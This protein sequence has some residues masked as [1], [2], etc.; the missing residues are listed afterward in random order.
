MKKIALL[1][2]LLFL[3][4]C[5]L[6][7]NNS[8]NLSNTD[9]NQN[10]NSSNQDGGDPDIDP[11]G[12]DVIDAELKDGPI[13]HAWGW[14]T[15]MVK[16]ALDDIKNAGYKSVQLSPLQ[17]SKSTYGS[18][19]WWNLYQ[20]QG[21]VI[22]TGSDNPLGNKDSLKEL[23]RAANQKGVAIIMDV[24]TNH[25]GGP[26]HYT[27]DSRVSNYESKIVSDNL[28]H[29]NG[30]V[31]DWNNRYQVVTRAMG[32]YPDVLTSNSYVQDRIIAMLNDY[33]D[34]G[35]KGFRFDAAKSIETPEDDASCNSNYWPRVIGAINEHGQQVNGEKP[36][37]YGEL[38]DNPCI[39][40]EAYT[41]Y[42]SITDNRQANKVR[43]GVLYNRVNDAAYSG[44][45]NE[46]ASTN[47]L[48]AESH[49]TYANDNGATYDCSEEKMNL[50]YAIQVSRKDATALFFARPANKYGKNNDHQVTDGYKIDFKSPIIAAANKLHNDF[51]GGSE[52]LS[53]SDSAVINVRKRNKSEGALIADINCSSSQKTVNVNP[54]SNGVYVDLVNNNEYTVKDGSVTVTLT[55]GVCVL[56]K[57]TDT[58]G[59]V[60]TISPDKTLF[61]DKTSVTINVR[62][63][64]SSYYT[65]NNG[66]QVQF[67]NSVTFEV[68]NTF[69][70]EE[71]TIT[72]HS[73]N[74]EVTNE[75]STKLIK[76]AYADKNF[77]VTNVPSSVKLAIW[78]WNQTSDS[79]WVVMEGSGPIRG[80]NL[81]KTNYVVAKFESGAT[82][83]WANK[84][85]QT[86]DMTR[87]GLVIKDYNQLFE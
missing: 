27:F 69:S 65:I 22:S 62:N 45:Y 35:V 14:T 86:G 39:R 37:V 23:T 24:I 33:I 84:Q 26:N 61:S 17:P 44:Y 13:L 40:Y 21:F 68:G 58:R 82:V 48:W 87:D 46:N 10:S 51:V 49:D 80:V 2:S 7:P 81:A 75:V 18:D 20:P 4:G 31:S 25:L 57:K 32:G 56:E 53:T 3:A 73:S 50:T 78:S 63:G 66:P 54:L 30:T 36:F 5:S 74:S 59:P 60:I 9:S 67:T 55:N 83:D 77:I 79:S 85:A 19:K 42:M 28:K 41:E 1:I 64:S 70:E 52:T 71:I 34:C 47:V 15:D 38:L 12:E 11:S 43:D 72:A 8:G 6:N 16:N 29:D 76:T